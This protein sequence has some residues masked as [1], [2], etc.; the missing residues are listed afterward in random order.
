[1]WELSSTEHKTAIHSEII[2]RRRNAKIQE[3]EK[4]QTVE[5]QQPICLQV[6]K[7]IDMHQLHKYESRDKKY[8]SLTS[9]SSSSSSFSSNSNM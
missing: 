5:L 2:M 3:K 4:L 6:I 1:M 7:S 9:S 8:D